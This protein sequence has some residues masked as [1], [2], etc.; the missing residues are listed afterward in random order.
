MTSNIQVCADASG[1]S[2]ISSFRA[3]SICLKARY[4]SPNEVMNFIARDSATIDGRTNCCL[5]LQYFTV[6]PS[7][8]TIVYTSYVNRNSWL[9]QAW[10]V[11]AGPR[12]RGYA[13]ATCDAHTI[14]LDGYYRTT[15]DTGTLNVF[16]AVFELQL[17]VSS[18]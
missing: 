18:I 17:T 7:W 9:W 10:H 12:Q 8:D 3:T 13:S 5:L 14:M 4:K 16:T 15:K 2:K 6:S 11:Q 1:L